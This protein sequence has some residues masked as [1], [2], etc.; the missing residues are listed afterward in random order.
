L[1][2]EQAGE[3]NGNDLDVL[4]FYTMS[5]GPTKPNTGTIATL[6]TPGQASSL[7]YRNLHFTLVLI[8]VILIVNCL[9]FKAAAPV[10]L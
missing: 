8:F 6:A 4:N 3:H 9:Y 10:L 7:N 1:I 5:W 2:P